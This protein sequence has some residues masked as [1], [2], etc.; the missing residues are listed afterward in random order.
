MTEG[1]RGELIVCV[2][3]EIVSSRDTDYEIDEETGYTRDRYRA[4]SCTRRQSMIAI[5]RVDD[6]DDEPTVDLHRD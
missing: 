4:R 2:R 1:N 6:D 3:H 5:G